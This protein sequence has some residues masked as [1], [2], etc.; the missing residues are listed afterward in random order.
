L[1]L[2]FYTHAGTVTFALMATAY[3]LWCVAMIRQSI[4]SMH[5]SR[6]SIEAAV[7]Y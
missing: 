1:K 4:I 6:G 3:V 5:S 2:L 7:Y